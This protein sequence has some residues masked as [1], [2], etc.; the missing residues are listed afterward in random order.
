MHKQRSWG[1]VGLND[2]DR[3]E[4]ILEYLRNAPFA[5][6]R[7]FAGRLAFSVAAGRHA[8]DKLDEQ[9]LAWEA[10]R[11]VSALDGALAMPWAR[12]AGV[13][14]SRLRTGAP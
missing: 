1:R 3:R 2:P 5:S 9:R 7:D 4:Q 10:R 6:A 8:I 13:C 11:G 12:G 14:I